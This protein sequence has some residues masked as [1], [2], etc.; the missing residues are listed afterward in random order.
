MQTMA[1]FDIKKINAVIAGWQK[2]IVE[3]ATET[4]DGE[5]AP[6]TPRWTP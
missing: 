2:N 1:E 3:P 4:A 6:A 5:G